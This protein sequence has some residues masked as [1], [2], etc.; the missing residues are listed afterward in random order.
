[1]NWA[2]QTE[3]NNAEFILERNGIEIASYE[4]TEAL[5]G[6]GSSSQKHP[7]GYIDSDVS[8]DE[9]YTYKL[10]SVDYSGQR[11]RYPQS[12]EVRVT[13]IVENQKVYDYALE[14]NYP[15]PFNPVTTINFTMKKAGLATLKIYD[16]LGRVILKRAINARRGD[17]VF[18]FD[19]NNYSSG[20]YFYQL[21]TEG[22]S[23]TLKMMLVK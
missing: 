23:R 6:H 16:M 3:S 5:K 11:H 10:L 2:T 17:N 9:T 14:Q 4:N 15:N 1:M 8:L 12:V 21:S 18:N 20:V 22:F 19:G 7:Y 13:E